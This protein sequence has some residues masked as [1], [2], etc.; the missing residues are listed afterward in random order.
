MQPPSR[1]SQAS[2]SHPHNLHMNIKSQHKPSKAHTHARSQAAAVETGQGYLRSRPP[3]SPP[4][5][6]DDDD[7]SS[8]S[9][10]TAQETTRPLRWP[11]LASRMYACAST[12]SNLHVRIIAFPTHVH[13]ASDQRALDVQCTLL[14]HTVLLAAARPAGRRSL[15]VMTCAFG[16][17][18]Q[19]A[20][21]CICGL[22]AKFGPRGRVVM[23]S[24]HVRGTRG[25]VLPFFWLCRRDL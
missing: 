25:R 12:Y 11:G 5:T 6:R 4:R 13:G 1:L 14:V 2:T 3:L 21:H 7:E 24:C 18:W 23:Y 17:S 22:Q 19:A 20:L 10:S 15:A 9:I 8:A 16:G